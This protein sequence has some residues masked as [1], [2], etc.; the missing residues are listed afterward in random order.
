MICCFPGQYTHTC[1][2]RFLATPSM[3]HQA[4]KPTSYLK[5]FYQSFSKEQSLSKRKEMI[6][7]IG[8]KDGFEFTKAVVKAEYRDI[9]LLLAMLK[10]DDYRVDMIIKGKVVERSLQLANKWKNKALEDLHFYMKE[11]FGPP[12]KKTLSTPAVYARYYNTPSRQ[13]PI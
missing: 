10:F 12:L 4:Y 7:S 6:S 13:T 1:V 2:T 3:I 11:K 9:L 8:A 5:T